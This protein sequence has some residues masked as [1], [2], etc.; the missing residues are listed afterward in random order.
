[1]ELNANTLDHALDFGHDIVPPHLAI[2]AM[3]ANG[4]RHAQL[5]IGERMDT[6][7]DLPGFGSVAEAFTN[8]EDVWS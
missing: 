2:K 4:Y 7:R 6:D 5:C 3:R 8:W 1:M